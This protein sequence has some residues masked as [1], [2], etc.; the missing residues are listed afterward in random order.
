VYDV[1][2]NNFKPD[3]DTIVLDTSN[4]PINVNN[5][6]KNGKKYSDGIQP[7]FVVEKGVEYT[8]GGGVNTFI[9]TAS[10][11]TGDILKKEN[12]LLSKLGVGKENACVIP[13]LEYVTN[14]KKMTEYY[15]S[16]FTFCKE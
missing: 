8:A 9:L 7:V 1:F 12:I 10:N 15:R 6:F 11:D 16:S 4:G 5:I 3:R 2:D 14:K 13:V